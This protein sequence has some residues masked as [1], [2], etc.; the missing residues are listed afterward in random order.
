MQKTGS[1]M[2]IPCNQFNRNEQGKHRKKTMNNFGVADFE[3]CAISQIASV[4][5]IVFVKTTDG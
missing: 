3:M 5:C 2:D 1:V 4:M